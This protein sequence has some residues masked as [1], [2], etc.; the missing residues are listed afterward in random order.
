MQISITRAL[1]ELKLLDARIQ[2][3]ITESV[4]VDARKANSE[5]TLVTGMKVT[6]LEDGAYA[7]VVDLI[8]RRQS[9]KSAIILSNANTKVT[10]GKVTMTVAEAIEQ[11]KSVEYKK[12]LVT[13]LRHQ[14]AKSRA[15]IQKSN[16]E[17]EASIERQ[18]TAVLGK[19]TKDS[20]EEY[21]NFTDMYTK[22]NSATLVDPM[23]IED[24][25]AELSLD[26]EGF[27]SEV[28]FVLSESNARTSVEV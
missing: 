10:I 18:A 13:H 11:K 9:V 1:S 12:A 14:L 23:K 26:V 6:Q 21:K 28:D 15:V 17:M 19:A 4:F 25:I 20:S 27:E 5:N 2:K 16:M 8:A 24:K 3:K 22:A 7:S